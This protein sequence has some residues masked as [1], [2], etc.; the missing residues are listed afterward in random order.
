MLR[1][2]LSV[3]PAVSSW[4]P[5]ALLLAVAPAA[6]AQLLNDELGLGPML[7][8]DPGPTLSDETVEPPQADQ[9][10]LSDEATEVTANYA[11]QPVATYDTRTGGWLPDC[12]ATSSGWMPEI[13]PPAGLIDCTCDGQAR[14]P[15][16]RL[17]RSYVKPADPS[18]DQRC[19]VC[20]KEPCIGYETIEEE[21]RAVIYRCFQSSEPF[22]RHGCEGGQWYEEKGAKRIRKLHPC[23]IK[24]PIKYQK[25]VV[26]YR[27]VYYYIQCDH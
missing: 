3:A 26:K 22:R 9:P 20:V 15:R 1:Q 21:E 11:A 7:D 14:G 27:D 16:C 10:G 18:V 23:E 4:L 8:S 12:N 13:E 24:V 2:S 25:P 5:V 17:W 6:S 19:V